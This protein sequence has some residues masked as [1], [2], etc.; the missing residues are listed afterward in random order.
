MTVTVSPDQI[1]VGMYRWWYAPW[2]L[3]APLKYERG[4]AGDEFGRP[5]TFVQLPL[6]GMFVK[7]RDLTE[8]ELMVCNCTW[9][10][11]GHFEIVET[12]P[13]HMAD[14]PP[15]FHTR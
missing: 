9:H 13:V 11:C 15:S 3:T 12:C 4:E 6:L 2:A 1:N 10:D 8:D 5:T 7:A 14:I